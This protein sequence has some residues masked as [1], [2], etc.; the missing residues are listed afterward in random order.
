MGPSSRSSR[1]GRA[2]PGERYLFTGFQRLG[3]R[4]LAAMPEPPA[5][6]APVWDELRRR[7]RLRGVLVTG[8]WHE[9]GSPAAYLDLVL[10]LLGERPWVHPSAAVAD[11]ARIERS[12]I[13]AGCRVDAGALV[14]DCVL[15]A[16]AVA[17]RGCALRGCV[18]AGAL[19][20]AG[21]EVAGTLLLAD[22]RVALVR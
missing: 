22:A 20:A 3:E 21:E 6:M 4:V 19:V 18:L 5:E 12:A 10:G 2:A 17:G 9:A 14:E 8:S 16:G 7:G 13:G 1:P 11:G 15:T